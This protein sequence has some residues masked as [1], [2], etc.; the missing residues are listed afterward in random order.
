MAPILAYWDIMGLAEQS[1]LLL[2]YLGV[3]YDEK[4]YMWGPGKCYCSKFS[5]GLDFPNLPYYIDDDF[6]LTQSGAILEYIADK[7]G[8]IPDCK[9]QRA[10]LHMLECEIMNLRMAFGMTCYSPNFEVLK[11]GFLD[12]LAQKLSNFETYLPF[13]HSFALCS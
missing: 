1:R 12:T 5:L 9:K 3:K 8:M 2:K 7:H 11:S 6:K 4:Q 13:S 10:V